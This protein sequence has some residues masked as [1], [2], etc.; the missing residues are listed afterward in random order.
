MGPPPLLVIGEGRGEVITSHNHISIVFLFY[1]FLVLNIFQ[2]LN[3]SI[4][5]YF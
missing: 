1:F 2:S 5:F 4:I 3:L